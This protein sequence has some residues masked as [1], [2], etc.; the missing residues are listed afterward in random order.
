MANHSTSLRLDIEFRDRHFAI[1]EHMSPA[2]RR[3]FQPGQNW[4]CTDGSLQRSKRIVLPHIYVEN[5]FIRSISSQ[6][7]TVPRWFAC[8][9]AQSLDIELHY[10]PAGCT[11]EMQPCDRRVFGVLKSAARN[12]FRQRYANN[13][14]K[15]MK[16]PE[17]VECMI[18]AWD[19]IEDTTIDAAWDCYF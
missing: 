15:Q 13:R 1:G 19:D 10:I 7:R 3:G 14:S 9:I 11:D 12:L 17:A 5:L 8:F 4:E 16:K 2:I 6:T 18:K